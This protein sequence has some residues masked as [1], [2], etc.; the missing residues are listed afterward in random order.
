MQSWICGGTKT[1]NSR[2]YWGVCSPIIRKSL[3]LIPISG[4]N[5]STLKRCSSRRLKWVLSSPWSRTKVSTQFSSSKVHSRRSMTRRW[6]SPRKSRGLPS[7][8]QLLRMQAVVRNW[9]PSKHSRTFP[10]S[11]NQST[12][13]VL[14]M[15]AKLLLK[16]NSH[17]IRLS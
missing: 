4:R 12:N 14:L 13:Q 5:Q 17:R 16:K 7:Q 1:T 11:K 10:A 2:K 3:S 15:K 9:T 8:V 6:S